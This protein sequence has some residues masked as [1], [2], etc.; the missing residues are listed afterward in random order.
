[1][2]EGPTGR[3]DYRGRAEPV[4]TGST[5]VTERVDAPASPAMRDLPRELQEA[6]GNA[7]TCALGVDLSTANERMQIQV[8]VTVTA[9]GVVTRSE[10]TSTTAPELIRACIAQRASSIHLRGDIVGAPRDVATTLSLDRVA[11]PSPPPNPPANP[12]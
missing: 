2:L 6:L 9:T 11:L 5:T 1:M 3:N 4:E 8:R 7:A 10:V 12:R